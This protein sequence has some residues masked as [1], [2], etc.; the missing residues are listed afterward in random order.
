M[1]DGVRTEGLSFTST[2]GTATIRATVWWPPEAMEPRGVVQIV[3]GMCEHIGR[4][5]DF[6]RHLAGAG[7]VVCGHDQ[8]GHGRSCVPERWGCLPARDGARVLVEDVETLRGIVDAR[9]PGSLPHI[10]FGHSMGSFVVRCHIARHG[11]GL[12]GAIIC[13]TGYLSPE[14]QAA[15]NALAR[16]ACRVL[17]EDARSGLFHA[18]GDGSYAKAVPDAE[19]PFDWLSYDRG[20]VD[21]YIEDPACGFVFS[22]GGYAALTDLTRDCCSPECVRA[23][24][25]DLP[26]YYVA[27]ED[28]PVGDCGRGVRRAFELAEEAGAEDASLR[29][30]PHMRHEILNEQGHEQV[31]ADLLAWMGEHL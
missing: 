31:Y 9:V 3:H 24:P 29:L 16:L 28:D 4:Y 10:L 5:D 26:L 27:G 1:A 19:T 8:L 22:L 18:L 30:W 17:G 11:R 21:A 7:L 15:C 14:S 13:G 2:E 25:R 20:N 12:A 23:V 6:A